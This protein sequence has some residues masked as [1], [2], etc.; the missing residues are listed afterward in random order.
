MKIFNNILTW[1][2][3][4]LSQSEDHENAILSDGSKQYL[5]NDHKSE[6]KDVFIIFSETKRKLKQ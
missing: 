3:V 5:W 4:F 6:S 1:T 2:N